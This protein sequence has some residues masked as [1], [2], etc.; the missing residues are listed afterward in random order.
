MNP[1]KI[2]S[3]GCIQS[4]KCKSEKVYQTGSA[5]LLP[6]S[7]SYGPGKMSEICHDC[8]CRM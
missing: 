2:I 3:L 6:E 7:D 1:Q 8:K 4:E 5:T